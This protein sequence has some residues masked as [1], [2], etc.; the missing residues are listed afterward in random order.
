[1]ANRQ[2]VMLNCKVSH[3]TPLVRVKPDFT[4]LS[5]TGMGQGDSVWLCF[6][7]GSIETPIEMKSGLTPFPNAQAKQFYIKKIAGPD[8]GSTSVEVLRGS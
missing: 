5:V 1:M 6:M 2:L 3:K 7:E 4:H 8:S